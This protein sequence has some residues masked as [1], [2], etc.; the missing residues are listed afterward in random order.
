MNKPMRIFLRVSALVLAFAGLSGCATVLA[1]ALHTA[2]DATLTPEKVGITTSTWRGKS[3]SNL[4]ESHAYMLDVQQKAAAMGDTTMTKTHG[5]QLDAIN[6]VRREQGC[7]GGPATVPAS[8]QVTAYGYCFS[9][10]D[11]VNYLTPVFTYR[12]F[13]SDGGAAETAAFNAM[14]L[15]TY[16]VTDGRGACL[17]EDSPANAAAAIERQASITRLQL[18]WD[19]VHVPWTPPPIEKAAKVATTVA[20]AP[21]TSA[22]PVAAS[23]VSSSV[24]VMDLGLTLESPSPELV[25]A[26]GLKSP[27]GAW[28]VSVASGSP[29]AKAGLKPMDVILDVSGQ[30]VRGPVDVQ[31]ITSRLRSGYRAPLGVWRDRAPQELALAIPTR[32]TPVAAVVQPPAAVPTPVI[33]A[34]ASVPQGNTFCHAYIYVVKKPGGVQSAIFQSTSPQITSAGMM[35]TLPAFVSKVRQQQP[36]TWRPFSFPDVQC[37][38]PSGY[39]FANAQKALFKPGQMAG[40]FCFATRAEAQTHYE[41]FNSVKPVYETLEWTP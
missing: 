31:S 24:E 30:E 10:T 17:M 18:N 13:Y 41:E 22:S 23:S 34:P 12:D 11:T 38:P 4:E 14:L 6:Q 39:C 16:G 28:V 5:W 2:L 32:A 9:S 8:G 33:A 37:S 7:F 21:S 35:T 19:T 29:A 20:V 27:A 25:S 36:E 40:Q 1:P 15:S 3:C 26:L